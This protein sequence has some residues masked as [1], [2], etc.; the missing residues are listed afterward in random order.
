MDTKFKEHSI[1]KDEVKEEVDQKVE[2]TVPEVDEK[3]LAKENKKKNL[4]RKKWYRHLGMNIAL[5][6]K[7]LPIT[8]NYFKGQES[9]K[10]AETISTR[11]GPSMKR[12]IVHYREKFPTMFYTNSDV[13]RTLIILGDD[14]FEPVFCE[15]GDE[16]LKQNEVYSLSKVLSY[17]SDR[18]S[19]LQMV[20]N[21]A[22][23]TAEYM[24]KNP[25]IEDDFEAEFGQIVKELKP[26]IVEKAIEL[27]GDIMSEKGFKKIKDK[28]RKRKSRENDRLK[29]IK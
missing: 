23:E 26:D 10:G 21:F 4:R 2:D 11:I 9:R 8:C 22:E 18:H 14:I 1:W 5:I 3:E 6:T 17:Y 12:K 7:E 24:L 19:V 27:V 29:V 15:Q 16:Q 25:K 20:V 28:L 13:I